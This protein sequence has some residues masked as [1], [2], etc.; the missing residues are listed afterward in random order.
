MPARSGQ[1]TFSVEAKRDTLPQALELLGEILREPA[2][3]AEEFETLEAPHGLACSPPVAP[4]RPPWPGTSS[5]APCRRY[6]KDDVRYVPTLEENARPHRAASRSNRSRRFTKRRSAARTPSWASSATSTRRARCGSVKE[7][8]SGW[9]SK[10]PFERIDHKVGDQRD[11]LEGGHRHAG[12]VERGIPRGPLVPSRRSD[13]DY[14]ALADRQ[15]HLRRQHARLAARRPHPPE[16]R[17]FVRRHLVVR[18]F[19]PRSGGLADGDRQHQPGEHRQGHRRGHGRTPAVP[20][21]RPD[22]QGSR[23]RED[24]RSSKPRKSA[25]PAT[26]R[27]PGR[28]SRT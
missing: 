10:V 27:S 9:E 26:R 24:R 11:R 21:G 5:A 18:R 13:P 6:S 14:P 1:L 19:V 22:R 4:N 8:L 3:P 23:R 12:Q 2:F 20:Q 25:A 28:S 17:T 15:L 16:G 7:M